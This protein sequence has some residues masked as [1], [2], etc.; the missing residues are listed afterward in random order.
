MFTRVLVAV[1]GSRHSLAAAGLAVRVAERTGGQV[2]ALFVKDARIIHAPYW[3]DFG[4]ISLPTARF[5]KQ[6][7]EFFQSRGEA[8]LATLRE[9]HPGLEGVIMEGRVD[10]AIV[11]SARDAD[12]LV[13]GLA[14]ESHEETGDD[15]HLGSRVLRIVRKSRRP[16]L[17]VPDGD[18]E[19]RTLRLVFCDAPREDRVGRAASLARALG[20]PL[21]ALAVGDYGMEGAGRDVLSRHGLEAR[22]A[23]GDAADALRGAVEP[24]DLVLLAD[25]DI[26]DLERAL[27]GLRVPVLAYL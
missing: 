16:A 1:D 15:E 17:L 26:S 9:R 5:D 14:G 8:V 20:L 6:L 12:L 21:V 18:V 19:L 24:G 11:R 13:M 27:A 3:R 4:A 2:L 7:D 25:D 23:P 22:S 10:E